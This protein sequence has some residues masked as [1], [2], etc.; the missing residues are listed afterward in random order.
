M[1][2]LRHVFVLCS[3]SSLYTESGQIRAAAKNS[4]YGPEFVQAAIC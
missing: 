3:G 2:F 1:S 4:A